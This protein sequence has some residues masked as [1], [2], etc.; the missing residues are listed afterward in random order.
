VSTDPCLDAALASLR[1]SICRRIWSWYSRVTGWEK[2]SLQRSTGLKIR[3]TVYP[4]SPSKPKVGSVIDQ[5]MG[6]AA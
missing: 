6:G 4:S 5:I 1:P 2:A 3:S